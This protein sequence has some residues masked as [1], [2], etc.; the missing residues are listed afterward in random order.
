MKADTVRGILSCNALLFASP[1][2]ISFIVLLL[3]FFHV[4]SVPIQEKVRILN[5]CPNEKIVF[6]HVCVCEDYFVPDGISAIFVDLKDSKVWKYIEGRPKWRPFRFCR[7]AGKQWKRLPGHKKRLCRMETQMKH[8][9][10]G[11]K[12]PHERWKGPARKT[13]NHT[14]KLK[15]GIWWKLKK[16][17][18]AF[19]ATNFHNRDMPNSTMTVPRKNL[20]PVGKNDRGFGVNLNF[21]VC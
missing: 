17:F 3:A 20:C 9:C 19:T 5:S 4:Y 11:N 8:E 16:S 12:L 14:I 1:R 6:A 10:K 2:R 15:D 7:K 18:A 13:K 21:S